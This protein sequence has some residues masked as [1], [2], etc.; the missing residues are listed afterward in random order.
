MVRLSSTI[1]VSTADTFYDARFKL[2][3]EQHLEMLK[4]SKGG[5]FMTVTPH[6]NE[7]WQ[8]NLFGYLQSK[9]VP[10]YQHWIIMRMNGM[11]STLDFH[12]DYAQLLL[13]DAESISRLRE[14]FN[15]VHKI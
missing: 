3:L 8:G 13:P 10:V 4:K 12:G 6:D 7:V 5:N 14:L 9:N 11:D 1:D 2:L 15:T